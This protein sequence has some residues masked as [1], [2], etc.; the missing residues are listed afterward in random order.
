MMFDVFNTWL[1]LRLCFQI[2][3]AT[4]TLTFMANMHLKGCLVNPGSPNVAYSLAEKEKG[5]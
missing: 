1:V 3:K 4:I 5:K 2:S